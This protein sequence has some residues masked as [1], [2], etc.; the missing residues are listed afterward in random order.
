MM[1][2][3]QQEVFAFRRGRERFES[4]QQTLCPTCR[5]LCYPLVFNGVDLYNGLSE[6][7]QPDEN[8]NA[9]T[10]GRRFILPSSYPG[11]DRYM[12]RISKLPR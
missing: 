11:G 8:A 10:V 2:L 6:S 7:L 1:R 12:Q 9:A 5:S 3:G 4:L